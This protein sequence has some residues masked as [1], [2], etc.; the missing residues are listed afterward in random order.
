MSGSNLYLSQW[1]VLRNHWGPHLKPSAVAIRTFEQARNS[2]HSTYHLTMM[3]IATPFS[4]FVLTA[5][6]SVRQYSETS[7]APALVPSPASPPTPDRASSAPV[8]VP[9]PAQSASPLSTLSET[10][11]DVSAELGSGTSS[12]ASGDNSFAAVADTESGAVG[13]KGDDVAL[14]AAG[15]GLALGFGATLGTAAGETSSLGSLFGIFN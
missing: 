12:E 6:V 13:A 7:S 1:L 8:P 14:G 9:A 3:K 11:S 2:K 5:A 10:N 4:L 15:P